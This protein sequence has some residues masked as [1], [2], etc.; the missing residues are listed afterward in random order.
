MLSY[1]F[2]ITLLPLP[3]FI[4]TLLFPT[5]PHFPIFC[6]FGLVSSVRVAKEHGQHSIGYI[7]KKNLE[8]PP[9]SPLTASMSSRKSEWLF[10]RT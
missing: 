4:N 8:T 7:I 6:V 3:A 5:G 9:P 1:S 2:P 10:L